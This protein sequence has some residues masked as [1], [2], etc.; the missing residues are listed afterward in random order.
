MMTFI[1][2]IHDVIK[3][4]RCSFTLEHAQTTLNKSRKAILSSI[5]HLLAKKE[6]ASP[7]RG[8]YVIVP[9]EYQIL[10]CI[11]AD[12]FIP[13]LMQYWQCDYYACLLTAAQY[14]GAS[15]QAVMIFQVMVKERRRPI[16]CGK[17]RIKFIKNKNLADTPT[18]QVNTRMSILKASTPEGTAMDLIN[19]P[20]QSAGLSHIATV[21]T[22]LQEVMNPDKLSLLAKENPSLPWQ[23]RLGYLLELV[24]A[25]EL[26][27][28]LKNNLLHQKR[29]DY[30]PLA[31]KNK[32]NKDSI[33]NETWRIIVNTIVE[34]DI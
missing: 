4:G 22:E 31:S 2:Y 18:Q 21:L 19:Y 14:H 24:N 27:D 10:G 16:S 7:A 28:V 29:V 9:P 30:I 34:S 20:K 5:E 25:S 32:I 23:Q 6:L 3:N 33:K 15:H 13:E 1:E 8:F 12:H 17:V 11:P 26:T